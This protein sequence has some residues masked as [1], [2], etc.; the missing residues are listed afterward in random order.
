[1]KRSVRALVAASVLAFAGAAAHAA[2]FNF[3]T[4]TRP[5]DSSFEMSYG[6][7]T[8][9]VSGGWYRS[10]YETTVKT[11]AGHGLSVGRHYINGYLSRSR[12]HADGEYAQFHFNKKVELKGFWANYVSR[13]DDYAI[14]ADVDGEMT[15]IQITG[16]DP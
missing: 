12:R 2:T 16:L 6:D 13:R 9:K 14:Y 7:L 4:E 5:S 8:M 15:R 10:D 11:D 1:M 3:M